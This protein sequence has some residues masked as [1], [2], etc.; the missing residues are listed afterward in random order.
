MPGERFVYEYLKE[1]RQYLS[2]DVRELLQMLDDAV[3]KTFKYRK[4]FNVEHPEYCV[5]AW[6]AGWYQIKA[7]LKEYEPETLK[8]IF[9]QRRKCAQRME[10]LVYELGFLKK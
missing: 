6:D 10:S 4:L 8:V 9:E 2:N 5:N 1:N 3:E 7:M